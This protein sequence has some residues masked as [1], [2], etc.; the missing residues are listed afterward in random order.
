MIPVGESGSLRQAK[1][2]TN[3]V[4]KVIDS[5]YKKENYTTNNKKYSIFAEEISRLGGVWYLEFH[6]LFAC[7]TQNVIFCSPPHIQTKAHVWWK[8]F[9]YVVYYSIKHLEGRHSDTR[10][11]P[12][13]SVQSLIS[14]KRDLYFIYFFVFFLFIPLKDRRRNVAVTCV[15]LFRVLICT[16][17]ARMEQLSMNVDVFTENHFYFGILEM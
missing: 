8:L 5:R 11:G 7:N 16:I 1:H 14:F 10:S 2:W 9:I 6:P 17:S 13:L 15:M 12:V 3:S 4:L